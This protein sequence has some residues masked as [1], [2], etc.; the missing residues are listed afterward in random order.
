MSRRENT[1][2]VGASG[3]VGRALF[4]GLKHSKYNIVEHDIVPRKTKTGDLIDI[5]ADPKENQGMVMHICIP[6]NE[7]FEKIIS[8]YYN[9]YNPKLMIIHSSVY[10]GTVLN[11]V[12]KKIPCVH[13]P[14]IFNENYSKTITIFRKMI[15][16]DKPELA[17]LAEEHL[18]PCFN[19]ALIGGSIN[20]E[21]ADI[22][23]GLYV[24]T[25][26]AT[27][28]EISRMFLIHKADYKVMMELIQ[29]NNFGYISSNNTA[30]LLLN[31]FPDLNKEDYRLKLIDLINPEFL[32]AFFKLSKK[33]YDIEKE[34]KRVIRENLEK[35]KEE[36]NNKNI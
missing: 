23:L 15:G 19:T 31:Y 9:E 18:R 27:I 10:P 1:I 6:Y 28:F 29:Y 22:C 36:L 16:Y 13:S 4:T 33:S 17:L 25:C 24:L 11:L 12:D 2:I 32:S 35:K 8:D 26:K 7:F 34:R 21:L 5:Q 3:Q 14:I 20:T 30:N